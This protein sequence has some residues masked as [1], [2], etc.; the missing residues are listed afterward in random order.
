MKLILAPTVTVAAGMTAVSA[1]KIT[2]EV[3]GGF[4][5]KFGE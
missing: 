1:N 3:I 5:I 2:Q 4:S